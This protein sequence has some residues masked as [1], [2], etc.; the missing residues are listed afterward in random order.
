MDWESKR[1]SYVSC[2]S[3]VQKRGINP[4]AFV[5]IVHGSVLT[6]KKKK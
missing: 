5:F 6:N 3:K 4:F 1:K 2:G